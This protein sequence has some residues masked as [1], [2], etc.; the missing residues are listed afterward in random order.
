MQY[1]TGGSKSTK[2]LY[3]Y[4]IWY[5]YIYIYIYLYPPLWPIFWERPIPF[6][7][8]YWYVRTGK[9]SSEILDWGRYFI[10]SDM[11]KCCKVFQ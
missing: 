9:F 8:Y 5:M 2:Y 6:W 10:S 1:F 7:N 11:A 4:F 3:F